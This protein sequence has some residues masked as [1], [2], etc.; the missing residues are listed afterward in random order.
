MNSI[1]LIEDDASTAA[2]LQ[3]ALLEGM[4]CYCE[5]VNNIKDGY[6]AAKSREYDMILLDLIFRKEGKI[7][8]DFIW[9]IRLAKVK[10]PIIIVSAIHALE[11][12]VRSLGFGADD[13]IVKP[14]YTTEIIARIQALARRFRGLDSSVCTIGPLSIHLDN[15]EVY[16]H[17]QPVILTGKEYAILEILVTR[18]GI[19]P[20][21]MFL[22]NLYGGVDEPEMKIIDVFICKLRKKL[23]KASGGVDFIQTVWG[24]GY[25]L[26]RNIKNPNDESSDST[27]GKIITNPYQTGNSIF[28]NRELDGL[29]G[30][31]NSFGDSVKSGNPYHETMGNIV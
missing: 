10:S 17:G 3:A 31:S 2:A 16:C 13:Y 24:R 5:V 9:K 11:S 26:N 23:I 14:Y 8:H 6:E 29:M 18:N 30:D 4:R 19:V 20:K 7:A 27:A 21:E 12:K 25:Q 15:K 28:A 22:N 1:L